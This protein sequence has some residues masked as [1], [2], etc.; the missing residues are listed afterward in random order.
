L[1]V[2]SVIISR[3]RVPSEVILNT[4]NLSERFGSRQR[5]DS[6][7]PCSIKEIVVFYDLS[8][9]V[10]RLW[11]GVHSIVMHAFLSNLK[12]RS[13]NARTSELYK[14]GIQDA[15]RRYHQ[16]MITDSENLYGFIYYFHRVK[17]ELDA[18]NLSKP[19]WDALTAVAYTDDKI[20]RFRSSGVFNLQDEQLEV[21]DLSE[22]PDY[23]FEDFLSM[24]ERE[25]HILY[26][27]FG[28]FDYGLFRF[29]YEK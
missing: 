3:T 8:E 28:R 27:E 17:T 25:D 12:P 10:W 1:A 2:G 9:D 5:G 29:S 11:M 20:I 26:V 22:M 4:K 21:L 24:I 14:N 15:F 19:I 18:D 13:V 23:V 6:F 16:T 7:T